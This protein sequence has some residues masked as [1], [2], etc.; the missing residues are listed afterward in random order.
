MFSVAGP[1]AASLPWGWA[2][3]VVAPVAASSWRT[4]AWVVSSASWVRSVADVAVSLCR[5]H[6]GGRASR[7]AQ[8]AAWCP[9]VPAV[10]E[11]GGCVPSA[12]AR[13]T[14]RRRIRRRH[15]SVPLPSCRLR[16]RPRSRRCRGLRW[17][18]AGAF[19]AAAAWA[20]VRSGSGS[21]QR[22]ATAGHCGGAG[23]RGARTPCGLGFGVTQCL[24]LGPQLRRL[25]QS[26]SPRHE[27]GRM[28]AA[29]A[30]RI[31]PCC[32]VRRTGA[33]RGGRA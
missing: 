23:Y 6:C 30:I 21:G 7:L 25:H 19:V 24:R 33:C 15:P 4:M 27:L 13:G 32:R 5:R 12:R 29:G 11:V 31:W 16:L 1:V 17:R 8:V 9:L 26:L 18:G 28:L 10:S 14:R 22:R 2:A 3:V 20:V